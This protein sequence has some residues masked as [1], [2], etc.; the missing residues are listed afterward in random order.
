LN[1]A[2]SVIL[3]TNDE[4]GFIT[5]DTPCVW[6]NPSLYKLPPFYRHPGLG[7]KDIEVTLPLTPRHLLTISHHRYPR[8][9]TINSK[10]VDE[11]N[12]RTRFHCAEEFV[13]WKGETQPYWFDPGREPE[14]T[15]EKSE[16]GKRA[17][18]E[19]DRL[20]KEL[21]SYP[22]D[23]DIRAGIS[24]PLRSTHSTLLLQIGAAHTGNSYSAL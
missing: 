23:V 10:A 12:R 17:V 20:L 24:R 1:G 22:P 6:F 2:N 13:S 14:D 8:Y 15:W 11:F 9:V 4:T 19:R 21:S 18:E 3:V 16:E 7:Q 5:S